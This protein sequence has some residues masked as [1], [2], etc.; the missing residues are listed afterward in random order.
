MRWRRA[1][2]C[3]CSPA[4]AWAVGFDDPAVERPRPAARRAACPASVRPTS[5]ARTRPNDPD[6]D[7]AEPDRPDPDPSTNIFSRALRPVRLRARSARR[8][9]PYLDPDRPELRQAAWSPASTPRARGRSRAATRGVSVAI[10]DTG[11][12]WDNAGLR[13]QVRLNAEE[14]PQPQ[15]TDNGA[16]L[17]G[18]DL[19]DNGVRRRGR[20]QGRPARG[21]AGAHRRRT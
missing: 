19:N 7:R 4:T 14:L 8:T 18:Y 13:T 10:L 15:P 3:S 1:W 12:N 11:I 6:Y 9:R 16:A 17:D 21:Q 20:L 2:R 5:S